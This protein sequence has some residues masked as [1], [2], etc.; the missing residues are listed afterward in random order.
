MTLTNCI[1]NNSYLRLPVDIHE[2]ELFYFPIFHTLKNC[3][4]NN[5]SIWNNV[6]DD[7][8]GINFF[9]LIESDPQFI[10]AD[11][12]DD[13]AGTIDDNLQVS[14]SSPAINAGTMGGL[15][16]DVAD[17][18]QDG[19]TNEDIPLDANSNQRIEN[20]MIDIGAYETRVP[21]VLEFRESESIASET[22]G[23][24]NHHIAIELNLL[25]GG[26]LSQDI[27]VNVI[28]AGT[29]SA[30]V[31]E[32]YE[33]TLPQSITF[34]KG[35]RD[36]D[37][38][39]FDLTILPDELEEDEETIHLLLE[40]INT[41]GI[42]G[43]K[44]VHIVKIGDNDQP[45]TVSFTSVESNTGDESES[46]HS[47]SITPF[48]PGGGSLDEAITIDVLDTRAGTA[49]ANS[50]YT[51]ISPIEVVF[52]AGF[53]IGDSL[54]VDV[55]IL[56]DDEAE[57]DETLHLQLANLRGPGR[58]G[59][60]STHQ[61][62][63]I[64]DDI[65]T[66]EGKVYW[67][68]SNE[69]WRANLDGTQKE[70]ILT[71]S[72]PKSLEIDVIRGKIYWMTGG[73]DMWRA[74]LNGTR[75]ED[76]SINAYGLGG[77]GFTLD[78]GRNVLYT[79]EDLPDFYGLLKVWD[80]ESGSLQYQYRAF[81]MR[82]SDI[83]FNPVN[84][85][86]VISDDFYVFLPEANQLAVDPFSGQFYFTT[87]YNSDGDILRA[88]SNGDNLEVLIPSGLSSPQ[89]IAVDPIGKRMYWVDSGTGKIQRAHLDGTNME[90]IVTGLSSAFGIAVVS[91]DPPEGVVQFPTELS[92]IKNDLPFTHAIDV[93]LSLEGVES[94]SKDISV[95]LKD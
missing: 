18:D 50:D 45:V 5:T 90:D 89:G 22:E 19:N 65:A 35:L 81:S 57:E 79:V 14:Y 92:V 23:F 87:F 70:S 64:D 73:G 34:P 43:H 4:I 62:T 80:I 39:S 28:D 12:P 78:T 74:N 15:P 13:I 29:G 91:Q 53:A 94:L 37:V 58:L 95:T 93:Q 48:R 36:G 26:Q 9:R 42:V 51:L 16:A 66:A 30:S 49:A 72:N 61:V 40:N 21:P 33:T 44:N 86:V 69:I 1:F 63:I 31:G 56:D 59:N 71:T 46:L 55:P 84:S 38:Q 3:I 7:K 67:T 20:E 24:G 11:G 76:L 54:A 10:D 60:Q 27:T 17:L 8:R 75:I 32:D 88:D 41:A 85:R 52:P 25:F 82:V 47:V 77:H 6:D 68:D 83:I 2:D